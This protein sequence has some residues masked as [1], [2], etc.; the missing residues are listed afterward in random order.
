[1]DTVT[2]FL[3]RRDALLTRLD[4]QLQETDSAHDA[5]WVLCEYT[6]REL[7][8]GDCVMYLPTS[9]DIL[10]QAAAWGPKRGAERMLESRLRLSI[11]RGIVG[12]CALLLQTQC[13][14]DTREDMRYIHDDQPGLSELSVP[15]SRD[16]ILLGVLDSEAAETGFFDSRYQ[17]AFEAIAHIGAAHLWRL[18]N[19][20]VVRR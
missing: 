15:L 7:N 18:R 13:V 16:G 10:V 12:E 14:D 3:E 6:G 8:L 2:R 9:G 20:A 5:A 17:Q 1:M 19:L 4:E 11:G